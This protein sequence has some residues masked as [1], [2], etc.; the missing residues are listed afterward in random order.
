M[1]SGRPLLVM[2]S[3]TFIVALTLAKHLRSDEGS[4]QTAPSQLKPYL[5]VQNQKEQNVDSNPAL[6]PSRPFR[7]SNLKFTFVSFANSAAQGAS[8]FT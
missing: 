3:L 6:F 5:A 4:D 2:T 1:N 8:I 7:A